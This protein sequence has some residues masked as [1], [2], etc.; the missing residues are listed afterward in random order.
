[1][2]MEW[3]LSIYNMKCDLVNMILINAHSENHDSMY[4]FSN[5]LTKI[6]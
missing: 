6:V 1:M 5:Q 2:N 3:L 4:N